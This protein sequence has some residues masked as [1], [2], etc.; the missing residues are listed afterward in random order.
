MALYE[1]ARPAL[2]DSPDFRRAL[3]DPALR[4]PVLRAAGVIGYLVA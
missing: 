1:R 3:A 2:P 4:V